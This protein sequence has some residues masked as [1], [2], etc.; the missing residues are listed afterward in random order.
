MSDVALQLPFLTPEECETAVRYAHKQEETLGADTTDN[1]NRYNFFK[2]HP[3][4]I[5]R[6]SDV[7]RTHFTW[8]QSPYLIQS[9]VN[10]YRKGEGLA[11][12]FHSGMDYHSMTANIF[13]GGQPTPGLRVENA[14]GESELIHNTLGEIIIMSCTQKHMVDDNPHDENRYTIGMTI[15]DYFSCTPGMLE[16]AA[17]NSPEGGQILIV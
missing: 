10:I 9:W 4:L 16:G 5:P 14:H 6:L 7:I 17:V 11:W 15:H 2:D 3:H 1:F 12:H 8:L 13:V